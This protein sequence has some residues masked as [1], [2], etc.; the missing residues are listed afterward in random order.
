LRPV[1]PLEPQS[2][3][4]TN[5]DNIAFGILELEMRC[6]SIVLNGTDFYTLSREKFPGLA[7]RSDVPK[8]IFPE[9]SDSPKSFGFHADTPTETSEPPRP[10]I[11]FLLPR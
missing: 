6:S 4:L 9:I 10:L 2:R 7:T 1:Q 3:L 11:E 5:L 8:T